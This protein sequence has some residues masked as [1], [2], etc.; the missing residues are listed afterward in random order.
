MSVREAGRWPIVP[1]RSRVRNTVELPR[2]RLMRTPTGRDTPPMVS[3]NGVRVAFVQMNTAVD[4]STYLPYSVALLQAYLQGHSARPERYDFALPVVR[5]L[6][7][8]EAV[9]H[10]G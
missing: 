1:E 5:R 4:D 10:L 7:P 9:R 2:T 6:H 3:A 8:P